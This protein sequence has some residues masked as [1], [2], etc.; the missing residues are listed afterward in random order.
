MRIEVLI[1]NDDPVV[2][3]LNAPKTTL[4]TSEHCDVILSSDGVSRKHITILSEGDNFY[5]ID[6]GSTNGSFINEERL[7]P[8]RKTEFTSFFPVRL[9]D[10][11]LV[12]L[13]SDEEGDSRLEIPVPSE[14]TKTSRTSTDKTS[15][16]SLRELNKVKTDK[17][18]QAR[19]KKRNVI[20]KK[21]DKASPSS[22]KKSQSNVVFYFALLILIGAVVYNHL[23]KKNVKSPENI[24][25]VGKIVIKKAQE[26]PVVSPDIIPKSELVPKEAYERIKADILC[27]TDIEIYLCDFFPGA[28]TEGFGAVQI[29]LTAHVIIDATTFFEE[30]RNHVNP[31][32]DDSTFSKKEFENLLLDTSVYLYLLK[33]S[34]RDNQLDLSKFSDMKFSI[35]MYRKVGESFELARILAIKP[36]VLTELKEFVNIDTLFNIR[37]SGAKALL[38]TK[39]KF[40]MY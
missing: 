40:Q 24:S 27:T 21:S 39:D 18:I 12:S 37:T 3:P 34:Q 8:G 29:G 15:V 38:S 17:L 14:I 32:I 11:V 33:L 26:T 19:D 7:I 16:I 22:K 4:G 31:A 6:Q 10:N 23:L 1:G 2:Y 20:K 9:G 30:A 36:K 35:A 25:E 28:R 5:V 13:I